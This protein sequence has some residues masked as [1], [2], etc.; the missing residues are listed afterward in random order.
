MEN[1]S[2]SASIPTTLLSSSQTMLVSSLSKS[3]SR[4]SRGV[5]AR[6]NRTKS[7]GLW[8]GRWTGR[9]D[10]L[11]RIVWH[12]D[13]PKCLG[14]STN[15]CTRNWRD[16][17]DKFDRDLQRWSG[18]YDLCRS[19]TF[20]RLIQILLDKWRLFTKL[21]FDRVASHFGGW[22]DILRGLNVPAGLLSFY[23]AVVRRRYIVVEM[24]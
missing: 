18:R 8:I 16:V 3:S 22:E 15:V 9:T 17:T 12:T 1:T 11:L 6:L 7:E 14:S 20:S 13:A 19:V 2:P 4:S 23:A 24:G 10:M 5:R 21:C